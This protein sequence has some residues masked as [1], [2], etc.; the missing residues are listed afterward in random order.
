M[1]V[2]GGG[3]HGV[4]SGFPAG[5]WYAAWR[6]TIMRNTRINRTRRRRPELLDEPR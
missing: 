3:I 6:L 5:E 1:S 2:V 4:S